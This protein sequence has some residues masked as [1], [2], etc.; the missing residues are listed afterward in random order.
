MRIDQH[1]GDD[2][3]ATLAMAEAAGGE[4]NYLRTAWRRIEVEAVPLNTRSPQRRAD[5]RLSSRS[6]TRAMHL[7]VLRDHQQSADSGIV[8]NTDDRARAD[9]ASE[10][11]VPMMALP[12]ARRALPCFKSARASL[13]RFCLQLNRRALRE[14][15]DQRWSSRSSMT[16][17]AQRRRACVRIA[18]VK[19]RRKTQG[20][21]VEHP[22]VS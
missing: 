3:L 17:S 20:A 7:I 15:A 5:I 18:A 10:Q 16:R 1:R 11:G 19:G 8:G 4:G 2:R 9:L 21:Q 13:E 6:P 12:V 22:F 14:M